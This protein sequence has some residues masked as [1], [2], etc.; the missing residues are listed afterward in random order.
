MK[1][2]Q[3]AVLLVLFLS[4]SADAKSHTPIRTIEFDTDESTFMC[5]D[6]SPDGTTL[7]LDLL[8]DLYT[9]P[10]TGGKAEPLLSGRAW[11]RCPRFSPDGR[12][13]AFISDRVGRDNLWV[14]D[15]RSRRLRQITKFAGPSDANRGATGTPEWLS[16]GREISYGIAYGIV[17][18][19]DLGIGIVPSEG[20]ETRQLVSEWKK[21]EDKIWVTA[22]SATFTPDRNTAFFSASSA[23]TNLE[24]TPKPMT[25]VLYRLDRVSNKVTQLTEPRTGRDE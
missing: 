24:S 12:S 19:L 23:S 14:L 5:V 15:L 21:P 18:R 1:N 9:L 3:F 4:A 22:Y 10:I 25:D 16:D 20:G 13:I 7:A 8:G 11:D 2:I 17:S 6:V